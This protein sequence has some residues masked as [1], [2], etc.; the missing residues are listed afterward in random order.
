MN[1]RGM[2]HRVRGVPA[3][4][5]LV[6]GL[7]GL[8]ALLGLVGQA[9]AGPLPGTGVTVQPIQSGI[10]EDTFQTLLVSRGLRRLGFDVRP[11]KEIEPATG[12][13]AVANGDATFL[14]DHWAPM[15]ADFYDKAGGNATL[16]RKGTYSDGAV[17]GYMIDKTTAERYNITNIGQLKDPRLAQL[18]DA[19]GDGRANLIGCNP[20]WG[21]EAVIEHQLTAFTL[22]DTVTHTQG[23]YAALMADTIAR[24]RQGKPVLFYTWSPYWVGGVLRPGQEVVWLEV[25]FSALPGVQSTLDTR[26]PNGKNYGFPVNTQHIVANK[27]FVR[28]YPVAGKLFEVMALPAADITAQNA[29]MRAGENTLRDIERHTDA[30]IQWHQ[31]T[32]DAWIAQALL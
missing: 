31:T 30:W 4:G 23:A 7:L 19:T 22:H 13:L 9:A 8:L 24:Y 12:H 2:R 15:H 21:C 26:L 28:K 27:A 1:G 17:Q 29:R 3:I 11:I 5:F 16:F 6:Q 14:A 10:A 20:G 32:F 18:F 25:P